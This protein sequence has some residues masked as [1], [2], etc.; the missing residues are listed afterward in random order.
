MSATSTNK[1][2]RYIYYKKDEGRTVVTQYTDPRLKTIPHFTAYPNGLVMNSY[3]KPVKIRIDNDGYVSTIVANL[4]AVKPIKLHRLIKYTFSSD[5]ERKFIDEHPEM[6]VNHIDGDKQNNSVD[7]LEWCTCKENID[8][9][10][11]HGLH[12]NNDYSPYKE[13]ILNDF[14]H[15]MT[16]A[17]AYRKYHKVTGGISKSTLFNYKQEALYGELKS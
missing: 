7:N 10:I 11:K 2:L 4:G 5:E 1:P 14:R 16:V 15:G 3:G 12:I 9:A 17:E 13:D 8:H 6:Q